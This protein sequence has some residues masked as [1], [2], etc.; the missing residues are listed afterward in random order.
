[1][2]L[3]AGIIELTVRKILMIFNLHFPCLHITPLLLVISH[4]L[5]FSQ[6][7]NPNLLS[8]AKLPLTS[9]KEAEAHCDLYY[10]EA[11][12]MPPIM[13]SYRQSMRGIFSCKDCRIEAMA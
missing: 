6:G 10:L 5:L 7:P 4:Y 2:R 1:M 13:S 11:A 8:Q 9:I 3:F 12:V